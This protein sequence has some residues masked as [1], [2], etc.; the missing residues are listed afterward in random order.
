MKKFVIIGRMTK[1][2][3][4]KKDGKVGLI[5]L[6]LNTKTKEKEIAEFFECKVFNEKLIEI[7]T[8]FVK[9]GDMVCVSGELTYSTYTK[10]D[11]AKTSKIELVVNGVELLPNNKTEKTE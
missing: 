1:E 7:I 6:A 5:T 3:E 10:K 4:L 9:K 8:K 11:G 2:I